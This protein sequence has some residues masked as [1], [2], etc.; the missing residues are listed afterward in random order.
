[1]YFR[2]KKKASR[3]CSQLALV[4]FR[5]WS[6]PGPEFLPDA[7]D[8]RRCDS[9]CVLTLE[10]NVRNENVVDTLN[11][12][13]RDEV[14]HHHPIELGEILL[15]LTLGDAGSTRK[16][17]YTVREAYI[18]VVVPL[19]PRTWFESDFRHGCLLYG[20]GDWR[21]S[22]WLRP[23]RR[24]WPFAIFPRVSADHFHTIPRLC[25]VA[26]RV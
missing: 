7:V 13:E 12:S 3:E 19:R 9:R 15:A 16:F 1:M 20:W 6:G 17:R 11:V 18:R 4:L 2:S 22:F 5:F 26:M 14:R 23:P 21:R 10:R 24:S 25:P 8:V